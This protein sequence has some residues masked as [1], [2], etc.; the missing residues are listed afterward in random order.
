M[1]VCVIKFKDGIELKT[2]PAVWNDILLFMEKWLD[3]PWDHISIY[4]KK[5]N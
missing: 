3:R 1:F 4:D 5:E 2:G